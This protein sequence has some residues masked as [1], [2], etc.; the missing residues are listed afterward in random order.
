MGRF[1]IGKPDKA[2]GD[3]ATGPVTDIREID[4]PAA[5]QKRNGYPS[6]AGDD[7]LNGIEES[8]ERQVSP[9]LDEIESL[10]DAAQ[11]AA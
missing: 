8:S 1:R 2:S 7:K 6:G 5:P 3:I 4:D 9:T 10:D 11:A